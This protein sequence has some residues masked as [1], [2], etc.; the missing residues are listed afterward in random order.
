MGRG[1]SAH[2]QSEPRGPP[3]VHVAAAP[4]RR[5]R[6]RSGAPR[7]F[8][9]RHRRQD[10]VRRGHR[11]RLSMVRSPAGSNRC[12]HSAS[13]S[14]THASTTRVCRCG[15]LPMAGSTWNARFAT[16]ARGASD[17]VVQVYLG[18]PETPPAGA[19]FAVRALA[20]FAADHA[21]VRRVAKRVQLHIAPERL[22]YWSM[23]RFGVACRAGR[24]HDLRWRDRRAICR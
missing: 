17:E 23:R 13:A 11:H 10:A 3:A 18:A 19:A 20:D 5:A 9:A 1:E 16:S 12:S 14:R 2:G 6:D 22:R 4:R 15:A 24:A 21:C 8:F 7:A